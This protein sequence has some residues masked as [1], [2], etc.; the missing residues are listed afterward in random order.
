MK[1]KIQGGAPWIF[2]YFFSFFNIELNN[3][4]NVIVVTVAAMISLTGSARNTANTLSA[5]KCGR[6]KISGISRIILR[7]QASSRLTF[8]WPSAMKLCWQLIWKPI[9]KMPAI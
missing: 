5:K 1:Y 2:Y 7:R 3:A 9:E 4:K 8:A 6:I